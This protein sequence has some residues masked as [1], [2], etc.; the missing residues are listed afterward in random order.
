MRRVL[1]ASGPFV[2]LNCAAVP[3]ELIESRNCSATRKARSPARRGDTSGNLSKR[4][5]APCFWMRSATCR[6]AMQAK[7]LRVLEE[8][9]V[10]RIGGEKPIRVD[11]SGGCGHASQSGKAGKGGQ[12]SAGLIPSRLCI[13]A[14]AAAAAR[15]AVR[16]FPALVSTLRGR[17]VSQNGWKPVPF[18]SGAPSKR[19]RPMHGREM[20]ASY[21][22][23]WSG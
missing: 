9:E 3:A 6:L 12:I 19:C 1:G 11:V 10:E 17:Y 22:M 18:S 21:A 14:G 16:I 23:L 5:A 7:L 13:S 2:T 4:I 20:F 15:S 8:G